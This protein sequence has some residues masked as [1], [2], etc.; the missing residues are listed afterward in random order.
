MANPN[1]IFNNISKLIQAKKVMVICDVD[2]TLACHKS[3]EQ[4]N[5]LGEGVD[6]A[7]SLVDLYEYFMIHSAG[8][9]ILLQKPMKAFFKLC[10]Q[11]NWT[12]GFATAGAAPRNKLIQFFAH[13]YGVTLKEDT[14]LYRLIGKRDQANTKYFNY[15]MTQ[16]GGKYAQTK[17]DA[18]LEL[19]DEHPNAHIVFM[20]NSD[21]EIF[22]VTKKIK[23]KKKT[24]RLTILRADT[25]YSDI[26]NGET[27]T[28]TLLSIPYL[29]KLQRG[30]YNNKAST[31]TDIITRLKSELILK[32]SSYEK[33]K[34]LEEC[35]SLQ[36]LCFVASIRRKS[37]VFHF[38]NTTTTGD[39]LVN[40]LNKT[41]RYHPLRDT[42]HLGGASVR[43]RD[44]RNFAIRAQKSQSP[45]SVFLG[46]K[47][48]DNEKFFS[49]SKNPFEKSPLSVYEY[50][51]LHKNQ[52]SG[53]S[54]AAT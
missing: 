43:M 49:H 46:D 34:A 50:Y 44:I 41:L 32:T 26:T 22:D 42:M 14:P 48:K 36:D 30:Q 37:G 2:H 38:K 40:L 31:N 47:D 1:K 9:Y 53:V 21:E 33:K 20:E 6:K 25:N 13:G 15:L 54:L 5:E 4:L 17:S 11:L 28:Q 8:C 39:M 7:N 27:L 3:S 19:M 52:E 23:E 18:I 29:I 45:K 16:G 10:N 12:I 35:T 24:Q 51:K